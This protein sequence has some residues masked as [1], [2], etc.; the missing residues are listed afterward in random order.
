MDSTGSGDP[1]QQQAEAG[2]T[3]STKGEYVDAIVTVPTG[4]L[5]SFYEAVGTW[6]A[7][8]ASEDADFEREERRYRG[9]TRL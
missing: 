3:T 9:K 1:A 2:G 6:W 5:A 7:S 4:L 8:Q